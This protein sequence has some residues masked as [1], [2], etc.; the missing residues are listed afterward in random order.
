MTSPGGTVPTLSEVREWDTEHLISAAGHWTTTATVW[1]DAFTQLASRILFPG[2]APWE[3]E[4]A[5]AAQQRTYSDKMAVIGLADQLHSASAIAKAGAREIDAARDA[6]LKVV[7]AAEAAGFTVGEDFSVTDPH[8]YDAVTAAARQAQAISFATSLRATVGT[9]VATDIRIAGE[10][11]SSTADLGANVF[12]DAEEEPTPGSIDHTVQLVNSYKRDGGPGA[13]GE[14]G[15]N[16]EATKEPWWVP[17]QSDVITGAAGGVAGA[18]SGYVAEKT[19]GATKAVPGTGAG[20]ASPRLT[21]LVEEV[22][23][24]GKQLPGLTRMGG[25]AGA[26]MAVP[27]IIKGVGEDGNSLSEATVREGAGFAAGAV[28]GGFVGSWIPVP[29]VGTA[30]GV[31]VGG[32]VG[33]EV[34]NFVDEAW[35][36]AADAVGKAVHGL[37]SVFSFG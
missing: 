19:H 29:V 25:I 37:A 6:V 1:E 17:S 12:P 3:G 28:V 23:V 18:S 15:A 5:E 22:T 9:L 13:G 16:A 35:E 7:D 31:A 33:T 14:G 11:T 26:A 30:I 27:T 36:P 2:G 20:R 8:Y 4:A 32:F 21:K 24:F 34:S 10:I